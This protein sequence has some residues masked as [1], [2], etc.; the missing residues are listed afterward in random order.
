MDGGQHGEPLQAE[1]DAVRDKILKRLG[2][3]VVRYP[4]W[5]CMK[6][7]DGVVAEIVDWLKVAKPVRLSSASLR[8][9]GEEG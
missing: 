3:D 9:L 7:A 4:A 6:Q 5:M 1:H 2:F 8:G